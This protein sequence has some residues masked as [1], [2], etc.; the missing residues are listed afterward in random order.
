[1]TPNGVEN[2]SSYGKH[3]FEKSEVEIVTNAT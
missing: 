2:K 3:F 1:M